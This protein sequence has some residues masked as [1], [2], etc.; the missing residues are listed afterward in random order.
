MKSFEGG[1]MKLIASLFLCCA[2]MLA[3]AGCAKKP[4]TPAAPAAPQ[5]PLHQVIAASYQISNA[6][7]SGE[8]EFEALYSS[9]LP[10][11]SDDGYARTVAGIFLKTIQVNQ[12]YNARLK[13]LREIDPVNKAQ[14]VAWTQELIGSVTTLLNEGVLGIKN[15]DARAKLQGVLADIPQALVAIS[16]VLKLVPDLGA[17]NAPPLRTDF[18][19]VNSGLKNNSGTHQPWAADGGE[20]CRVRAP[21]QSSKRHDRRTTARSGRPDQRRGAEQDQGVPRQ[22]ERAVIRSARELGVST[23]PK[24][25]MGS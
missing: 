14:V 20:R 24:G 21:A 8:K 11:V 23:Y 5:S 15:P 19:E 3:F 7:D 1:N 18:T 10:G 17:L 9:G 16:N 25:R 13:T 12:E 2:L 6:L 4:V 22:A